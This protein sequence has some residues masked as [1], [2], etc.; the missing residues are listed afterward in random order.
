MSKTRDLKTLV[1]TQGA[2]PKGA[3]LVEP[4]NFLPKTGV[5]PTSNKSGTWLLKTNFYRFLIFFAARWRRG[6][7]FRFFSCFL[8]SEVAAKMHRKIRPYGAKRRGR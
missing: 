3:R 4:H 5:F 2:Q 8:P 7:F 6:F 1:A